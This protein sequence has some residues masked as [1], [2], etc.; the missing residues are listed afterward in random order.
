MDVIDSSKK[1]KKAVHPLTRQV[2]AQEWHQ[3]G[4]TRLD[5]INIIRNLISLIYNNIILITCKH[6]WAPNPLKLNI[7][8]LQLNAYLYLGVFER[9]SFS[10]ILE[11]RRNNENRSRFEH[12]VLFYSNSPKNNC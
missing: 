12:L 2:S 6:G 11:L 3:F 7:L 5:P 8:R 9:Q 1:P 10:K 4:Q